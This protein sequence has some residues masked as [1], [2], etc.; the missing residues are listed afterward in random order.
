MLSVWLGPNTIFLS[1]GTAVETPE[2]FPLKELPVMI[3]SVAVTKRIP[4]P[5]L[6]TIVLPVIV[7]S[8]AVSSTSIPS[9]EQ[10]YNV[11]L[12]IVLTLEIL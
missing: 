4:Y 3:I 1:V 10:L 6:S 11:L 9:P 5:P 12:V 7:K 8:L 2:V